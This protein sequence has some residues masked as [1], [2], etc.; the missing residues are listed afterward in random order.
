MLDEHISPKD[1]GVM[2]YIDIL[3]LHIPS[4]TFFMILAFIVAAICYKLTA[5]KM[6]KEKN[7]YRTLII[8]FA[9]LGGILGAKLPIIIFN[10]KLLFQYPENISLLL[11]GKTIVGGLLGG[12]L[13]IFLLKKR[14]NIKM[15]T[16]ND[17]AA[18]AALGMAIGRLGCFFAGCCYGIESPKLLGVN[19][20][21][22]IYRYPTQ[23]YEL[24]FDLGLFLCFLYL[25]KRTELKPGILF[26]YLIISYLS[27]RFFLEFIRES[28]RIILGIS[29]YQMIC[30]A[31]VIFICRKNI[32]NIFKKKASVDYQAKN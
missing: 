5:V 20:G 15:K 30:L 16:G 31:S 12:F 19:F 1:F 9:L 24:A 3:N 13:G 8:I 18:P 28:D 6:D 21:D 14:L 32:K 27:F 17:I 22:G 7:S 26:R 23:L 25:K 10:Y 29:Y 2:H 4:Y 11:S